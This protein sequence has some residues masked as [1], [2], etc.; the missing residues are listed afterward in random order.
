MVRS[1]F[2]LVELLVATAVFVIGFA[3]VFGLFLAGMRFRKLA[4]DTVLTSA[5]ASSLVAEVYLDSGKEGGSGPAVPSWYI[6][7]GLA[8]SQEPVAGKATQLFAYPGIPG[9]EYRIVD[10]TDLL[11]IDDAY[12]TALHAEIVAMA[13]GVAL[14]TYGD[15]DRRVRAYPATPP[16]LPATSEGTFEDDLVRRGVAMKFRAVIVRQPHWMP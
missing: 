14:P 2:T 11:Q 7:D 15:L 9:T 12:A 16:A 6:G 13:P 1:G 10:C 4:D 8:T 3:A 5:L